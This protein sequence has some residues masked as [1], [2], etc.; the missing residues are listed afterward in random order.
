MPPTPVTHRPQT[1]R[2][3]KKAYRKSGATVRLSESEKAILERR[4]VLQERA[5]RIKEREARRKANLKRKEERVQRER[6]VRHRMGIPTPPEKERIQVGPS[7]LHLSSFMYAG[8]KRTRSDG[9]E[10]EE[11]EEKSGIQKE[12]ETVVNEQQERPMGSSRSQQPLQTF[13]PNGSPQWMMP[14]QIPNATSPKVRDFALQEHRTSPKRT[15]PARD[16]LKA[17]SANP[18][19][20]PKPLAGNK[21]V[22][23]LQAKASDLQRPQALPKDQPPLRPPVHAPV[24][25]ST[26]LMKPPLISFP[27]KPDSIPDDC[28]DD[29]F[30]TNTQIQRELSPP[31]TPP[32]RST[33]NTTSTARPPSPPPPQSPAALKPPATDE[34]PEDPADL[35]AFIS[36]QDLDFSFEL[37]QIPPP[38]PPDEPDLDS[39]F[40]DDGLEDI[41][42]EFELKS[43]VKASN[44]PTQDQPQPKPNRGDK[45]GGSSHYDSDDS[46]DTELQAG[47]H[48]VFKDYE[49]GQQGQEAQERAA[50]EW[51][52]FDLST[53]EVMELE[54]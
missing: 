31:P 6:E 30:V 24:T 47:L 39:D 26:T 22:G 33:P 16:P 29:F 44:V 7:Q 9:E 40:P 36:T 4:A 5:D 45:D 41:V 12:E 32:A 8:V 11:E 38:A 17:K 51:D 1:L 50:A 23:G 21:N 28:F 10:E 34:D 35:L 49:N 46:D 18:M 27:A 20:Q 25:K 48:M 2:Q 42:L 37:T 13:S 19:I 3:A 54:T 53:Q 52:A 14:S 15:P 43:P